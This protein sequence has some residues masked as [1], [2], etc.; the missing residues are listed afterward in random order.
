MREWKVVYLLLLII[1]YA[2]ISYELYIHAFHNIKEKE[3]F[4]EN[5]LMI[6]ATIG[7]FCFGRRK[8]IRYF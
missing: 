2:I 1:S 4:D 8:P 7:A 6:L 5:I 3:F